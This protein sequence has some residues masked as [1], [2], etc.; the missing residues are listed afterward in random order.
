MKKAQRFLAVGLA[1][2]MAISLNLTALAS[3]PMK[4]PA[5]S[6]TESNVIV[7]D[8]GVYID[9]VYYTQE[10]FVK[11][12]GTAQ[13][14]EVP[15]T[16]SA[17]LVAGTW[18]I[19]GIGQVIVTAAGAVIIAGAVV[20]VGSWIYNAVSDWFAERAEQQEYEDAKEEGA[21]TD[22]HSTQSTSAKKSLPPTGR[23]R[24]SKDLVDD[25]GVKQRRYYDKNGNPDLDIDYRHG[26]VG[27]K[28]PHRHQ[29]TDGQR[30]PEEPF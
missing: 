2:I 3:S 23:P 13:E 19:P 24:S 27:H 14:I 11:L 28:F 8:K 22:D 6:G 16:R 18:W 26:G 9:D 15:Q 5:E 30:G 21:P 7:T 25:E 1:I 10:Q 4:A 17:A 20:E 12:L 29:W